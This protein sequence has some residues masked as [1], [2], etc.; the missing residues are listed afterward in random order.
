MKMHRP[1]FST[2]LVVFLI[3]LIIS[4][5]ERPPDPENYVKHS[6]DKIELNQFENPE[7]FYWPAYFWGWNDKTTKEVITDQ[8]ED[9]NNH[10]AKRICL[11]PFPKAFRPG[12]FF[13]EPDYMTPEYL[14]LWKYATEECNRLDM[15]SYLYDEGGWPSGSCLGE[16]IKQNP[17][18][19]YQKL[20]CQILTPDKGSTFNIPDTCITAFLYQGDKKVNQLTPGSSIT[21]TMD[22]ARILL[23]KVTKGISFSSLPY[24]DLLNPKSTQEFLRLTHEKYKEVVGS[25]FGSTVQMTFTD[26]AQA[27]NPGWTNDIVTDFKSKFGY[28]LRDELPSIF[29]GDSEHDRKVR[30]DYFNWWTRR[31]ADS[32][33]GQIQEWCRQ[34]NLLSS[35]HLNGEDATAFARRYGYGHPLRALRRMDVPGIDVIWRQIWPWQNNHH[36]PKYASTVAHQSG[37]PWTMTESFAIYGAGLTPSQMKWIMDYQYVRGINLLV[38]SAYYISNRD[39]FLESARHVW[40][41]GNPFWQ[42]IYQFHEYIARIGYLT[43]LGKPGIKTALYYPINDIWAGGSE[44]DTICSSHDLLAKVLLQNQCDFDFIDDDILEQKSTRIV[45][46][47]IVVGPMSYNVVCVSRNRYMSEKSVAKLEK[48]IDEGGKV[49]WVDNLTEGNIPK[50]IVRTN[51]SELPS[52]I[53]PVVGLNVP[54]PAIRVHKRDLPNSSIYYV[55]NEDTIKTTCTLKFNEMRPIIQLDPETGKCWIPSRAVKESNGWK[56]PVEFDFAG[57][58]VFIFTDESFPL[59][60]EP[61]L[62]GKELQFITDGWTA[63][64]ITAFVVGENEIEVHELEEDN[65][66]NINLGDWKQVIGDSYSGDVEY[67]VKFNCTSDIIKTARV[68]DLGVVNYVSEVILNGESLGKRLWAPYS[69]DIKGK[70]KEGENLLKVIVTN[71]LVNQNIHTNDRWPDA[72]LSNYGRR[73]FI[74]EQESVSSGLFGPVTIM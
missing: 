55:T 33:Y 44:L 63:R 56:L 45:D 65:P 74:Y 27:A 28:D 29:E 60:K 3:T 41:P 21:V 73:Y 7:S 1:N 61:S 10:G 4:C 31:H 54:N 6:F 42:H 71:S 34:N 66:L 23:F 52:L 8:L 51:I 30:I 36:F 67:T 20:T 5:K 64:K 13:M 22:N 49:F 72:R 70:I 18:L 17:D 53:T 68:L 15:K 12:T 48:L 14:E 69:Y 40:G 59:S 62:P 50:G 16:V 25:H 32:Y 39:R 35:G 57:S 9:M 19:A 11:H 24:P 2:F 37:M 47:N 26:E 46:G 43:S 58:R 38:I